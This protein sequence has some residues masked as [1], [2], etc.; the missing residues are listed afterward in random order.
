MQEEK[1]EYDEISKGAGG[2][3]DMTALV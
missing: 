3:N 1:K 2:D